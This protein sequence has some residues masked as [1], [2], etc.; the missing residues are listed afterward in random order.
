MPP[1]MLTA[2]KATLKIGTQ[3]WLL[4][5]RSAAAAGVTSKASTKSATSIKRHDSI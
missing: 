4:L 5:N 1:I 3:S 2:A